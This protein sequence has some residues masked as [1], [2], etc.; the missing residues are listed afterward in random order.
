M[1]LLAVWLAEVLAGISVH[2]IQ[3]LLLC[4][5]VCVF[6]LL[7]LSLA[8]HLG[9]VPAYL[10]AAAAITLMIG[11]YGSVALRSLRRGLALG[12]GIAVLYGYLYVVLVAEDYALL[13]GSVGLF[14]LLA[15]VMFATRRVDW[16]RIEVRPPAAA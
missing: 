8:E 16:E 14:A 7:E 11:A 6:Y 1:T 5:A 15:A 12:A 2:P 13:L 3:S 4:T 10:A 9:F